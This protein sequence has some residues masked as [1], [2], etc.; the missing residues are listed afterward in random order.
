MT[1]TVHFSSREH[2]QH[3]ETFG[4]FIVTAPQQNFHSQS[5]DPSMWVF[6]VTQKKEHNVQTLKSLI[7]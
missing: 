5:S 3:K 4:R 7:S 1:N 6:F 2:K